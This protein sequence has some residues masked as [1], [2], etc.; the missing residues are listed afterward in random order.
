MLAE[1]Y[2][3]R[4]LIGRLVFVVIAVHRQKDSELEVF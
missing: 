1:I 4:I 2:L 3:F